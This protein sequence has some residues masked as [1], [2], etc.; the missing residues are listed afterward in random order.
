MRVIAEVEVAEAVTRMEVP[1]LELLAG[2]EMVTLPAKAGMLIR[3]AQTRA[4]PS[5]RAFRITNLLRYR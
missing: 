1:V 5:L 4:I 3:D 2:L